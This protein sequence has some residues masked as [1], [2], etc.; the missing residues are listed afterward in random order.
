MSSGASD[1]DDLSPTH[2]PQRPQGAIPPTTESRKQSQPADTPI[3][4]GTGSSTPHHHPSELVPGPSPRVRGAGHRWPRCEDAPGFIPADGEQS[5]D[6]AASGLDEGSSPRT[7]GAAPSPLPGLPGHTGPSPR[8]RGAVSSSWWWGG[9]M[10]TIPAGAESRVVRKARLNAMGPIP[11]GARS[12]SGRV[13]TGRR[14]GVHPRVEIRLA[15]TPHHAKR[16]ATP[17]R[18]GSRIQSNS[19]CTSARAHPRGRGEQRSG[20]V[21]RSSFAGPSLRTQASAAACGADRLAGARGAAGAR[22]YGGRRRRTIPAQ[23]RGADTVG[24]VD[25]LGLGSIPTC[26]RGIEFLTSS[27]ARHQPAPEPLSP[28]QTNHPPRSPGQTKEPPVVTTPARTH[29]H[30]ERDG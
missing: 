20:D 22:L 7:Q 12:R 8:A 28:K 17:A 29:N 1:H 4:T 18:T 25:A 2:P 5:V 9:T 24:V 15:R 13:R 6:K 16:G 30:A 21:R 27:P 11:A 26:G 3:P 10:G 14:G 23:A 19:H